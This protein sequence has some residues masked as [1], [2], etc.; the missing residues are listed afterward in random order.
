M[1]SELHPIMQQAIQS[2]MPRKTDNVSELMARINLLEIAL[3]KYKAPARGR[4]VY[5]YEWNCDR[6]DEPV[7]CHLDYSPPERGRR[8]NGLQ[9]EPDYPAE[10]SL[11]SAYVH[12]GDIYCLLS[13]AVVD[14]VERMALD[15]MRLEAEQDKE[16]F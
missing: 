13:S 6:L 14:E 15:D 11:F 1:T 16:P 2:I 5:V 4:G 3:R 7:I 8:E 10:M 12:G 9:M